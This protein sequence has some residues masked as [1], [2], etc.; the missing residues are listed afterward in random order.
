LTGLISRLLKVAFEEELEQHFAGGTEN[1][2]NGHNKKTLRTGLGPVEIQTPRDRKGDFAPQI[3]KKWSRE[4]A[5]E[6]I[7]QILT[8]YSMGTSYADIS[9]QLKSIYG[10]DY[11]P[12]LIT[13]I[14]D[15]VHEEIT[16]WKS[17]PL[18]AVYLIIYLDAIHFKV[19]EDREVVTKAV[20][21]IYGVNSKG[22]RD[23]LGLFIGQAE[24]AKHWARVLENIRERGVQDVLF[25]CVDGLKGFTGAIESIYPKAIVQRCIVHM[26]RTSLRFVSWKDY[27]AVC[28][29]LKKVYSQDT[30]QM[31]LE[32]LE[33]FAKTW[34]DKHPEIAK[35]WQAS[36][37]ELSPCFDYPQEIRRAIY[38]TNP[39]EAL[40]RVLR[41]ATKTK[42]A[43]TNDQA[44][45]KQLYLTLKYNSKSWKRKVRGWPEMARVF[46]SRFP[47]R[48]PKE[49]E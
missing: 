42:G 12:A 40:H 43:F 49:D 17:R 15:R 7:Q 30:E 6:L 38:T 47:D 41:K 32:E 45:E 20:Y 26:V 22:E 13:S 10:V 16:V 3:V 37:S 11:S 1:R 34:K 25:F 36:W 33:R 14:T 39:V 5:P 21:S 46:Q 31:A 9:A 2:R 4:L 18:E 48:F 29:D 8:L 44:L 35:K 24:G 23:V 28:R 27:R 19:R